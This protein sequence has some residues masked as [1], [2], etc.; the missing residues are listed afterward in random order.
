MG[1]FSK[2]LKT[3]FGSLIHPGTNTKGSY[4]MENALRLYY[5]VAIIPFILFF[6]FGSLLYSTFGVSTSGCIYPSSSAASISCVPAR[7]FTVFNS[8]I[9]SMAHSVGIY[10]AVFVGDVFFLLIIP[11]I[12]IF[13]DSLIYQLIG[14]RFLKAFRFN[15][16]KTFS[17]VTFSSLPA[18]VLY[19]LLFIPGISYIMLPI[20]TVWGFVVA[21][22]ALANQQKINRSEAFVVYLVTLFVVLLIA[23]AVGSVAL[24]SLAAQPLYGPV[25]P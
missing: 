21:I 16:S 17:A 11:P 25:M 1:T 6:I 3:G 4:S 10:A 15:L 19:W 5:T 22:I 18:L 23:I 13:V 20:M 7:Y 12:V 24:G 8:F 2:D 9:G 14:R